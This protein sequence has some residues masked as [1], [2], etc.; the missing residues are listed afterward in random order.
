MFDR[1]NIRAATSATPPARRRYVVT[2][3]ELPAEVPGCVRLKRLL[4]CADRVFFYKCV[5]VR[6]EPAEAH[7]GGRDVAVAG[8]EGPGG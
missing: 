8:G 6:E 2:L 4:K 7:P 3:E 1:C 5:E